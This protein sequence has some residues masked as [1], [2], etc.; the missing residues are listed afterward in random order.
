MP[1]LILVVLTILLNDLAAADAFWQSSQ[2]TAASANTAPVMKTGAAFLTGYTLALKE[3]GFLRFGVAWP[4][5]RFRDNN[6]GTVTDNA[7]GLL[8]LKN[9]NAFGRRSW[10]Q[11]L[12]DCAALASGAAGLSDGSTSGQ[13][14]LPNRKELMSLM[15]NG[16]ISQSLPSGQPFSSVQSDFYWSSTSNA[17]N[18]VNAWSV[19]FF[20]FGWVSPSAKTTAYYAWPVRNLMAAIAP[21][22]VP[23]TGAGDLSA[24]VL[25]AREDG[26]TKLGVVWPNPRFTNNNNGTVT[27]NLTKLVWLRNANAAGTNKTWANA[28]AYCSALANGQAGLTDGSTLGQWRLPNVKELESLVCLGYNSPS[29]S[30]TAGTAKWT[31]GDP[32]SS[33]QSSNYWT[34]TSYAGSTSNAHNI[35][36]TDGSINVTDKNNGGFT[37]AVRAGP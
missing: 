18:T 8:W 31:A 23:A 26:M 16:R 13:W 29:L 28:L 20:N 34:S 10:A 14:R 7:T 33:V 30:N 15:D 25:N 5:P 19:N 6:N 12:N 21:T 35:S 4:H 22:P 37:W 27:D 2:P 11:A 36:L 3:D 24:Y 32:F 17:G 9:S 1:N